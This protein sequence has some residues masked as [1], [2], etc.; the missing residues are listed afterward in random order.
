M[1]IVTPLFAPMLSKCFLRASKFKLETMYFSK[2]VYTFIEG[3]DD[4]CPFYIIF[5]QGL[6]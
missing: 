4:R 1:I 2:I 6:T 3:A 5:A